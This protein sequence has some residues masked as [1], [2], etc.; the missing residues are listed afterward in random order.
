MGGAIN[1]VLPHLTGVGIHDHV[2]RSHA[3]PSGASM[4][5]G[6]LFGVGR[7]GSAGDDDGG[8]GDPEEFEAEE[9][10]LV[11]AAGGVVVP[12]GGAEEQVGDG[13]GYRDAEQDGRGG[14]QAG[15]DLRLAEIT[16][17]PIAMAVNAMN[18]RTRWTMPLP[19]CGVPSM[20]SA[21]KASRPEPT[22]QMTSS[23]RPVRVRARRRAGGPDTGR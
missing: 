11:E 4:P 6:G 14:R 10:A 23:V 19:C 8:Y 22:A 12:E 21:K 16:M 2:G 18:A 15:S 7:R 13:S 5:L 1:V 9:D 3:L 17:A 20:S